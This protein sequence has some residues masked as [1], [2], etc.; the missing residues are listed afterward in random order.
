MTGLN[1]VSDAQMAELDVTKKNTQ[2]SLKIEQI[3]LDIREQELE[4][5]RKLFKRG[6]VSQSAVDT[7][8]R[9]VLLQNLQVQNL[10]NTLNLIPTQRR[11]LE[12]QV[13]VYNAQLADAQLDLERTSIRLPFDARIAEANV[14]ITQFAQIGQQLAIADSIKTSEV[15][16]QFPIALFRD[17]LRSANNSNTPSLTTTT[18]RAMFAQM[19]MTAEIRLRTGRDLVR[20]EGRIVRV[21]DTIDPETRTVG[22]VVAV[23]DTYATAVPGIRPPLVKGM[24]VEVELSASPQS[25]KLVVPRS[26]IRNDTL[27]VVGPE[28]RLQSREVKTGLLLGD[29][30]VVEQGLKPGEQVVITDLIPALDGMQLAP[31]IDTVLSKRLALE[32]G[33][34]GSVR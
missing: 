4:R 18:I 32:V 14:E 23:D 24:Y 33:S 27:F 8:Q 2:A 6:T 16:A 11:V 26:A 17:V 29:F 25:D 30:I 12:E 20:W 13:A 28:N 10:R 34:E 3:S 1:R 31:Q 22:I 7:E 19:G 5:K 21:F 15:V 9:S